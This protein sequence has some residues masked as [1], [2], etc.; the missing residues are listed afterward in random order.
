MGRCSRAH[1][2]SSEYRPSRKETELYTRMSLIRIRPRGRETGRAACSTSVEPATSNDSDN[3]DNDPN[4]GIPSRQAPGRPTTSRSARDS[5]SKG[6]HTVQKAPRG[7][8]RQRDL[9]AF[10]STACLL[11]LARGGALDRSCPNIADHE[12]H[13]QN[14]PR[15]FSPRDASTVLQPT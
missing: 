10:C 11:E 9:G 4:T 12:S 15:D 6:S 8:H 3:E 7:S 13:H 14:D 5:S 1:E 2:P